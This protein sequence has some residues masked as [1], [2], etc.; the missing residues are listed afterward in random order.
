MT[1][2]EYCQLSSLIHRLYPSCK[3][4]YCIGTLNECLVIECIFVQLQTYTANMSVDMTKKHQRR[5]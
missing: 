3:R 4:V 1:Q 2:D 5:V